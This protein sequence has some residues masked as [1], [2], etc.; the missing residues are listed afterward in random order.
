MLIPADPERTLRIVEAFKKRGEPEVG[1]CGC[2][3]PRDLPLEIH[4]P[5][6]EPFCPCLMNWVVVDAQEYFLIRKR[7][8]GTGYSY[9]P[10]YVGPVG[11]PYVIDA[12]GRTKA[13]APEQPRGF[14]VVN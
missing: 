13:V 8:I 14:D 3:G 11:G 2:M 10:D 5:K 4:P 1:M 9:E 6:K 12:F 7:F